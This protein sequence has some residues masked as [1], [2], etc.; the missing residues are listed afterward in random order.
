MK[1]IDLYKEW[2]ETGK[3]PDWGLCNS[4]PKEYW[5]TLDLFEPSQD[6][7]SQLDYEGLSWNYWASGLPTNHKDEKY[8]FTPLRQTIVLLI[9]AMKDEI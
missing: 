5:E 4:I 1:L 9:C 8:G 3:L 7:E 6:E 2:M